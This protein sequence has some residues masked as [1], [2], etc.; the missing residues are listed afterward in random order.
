MKLPSPVRNCLAGFC[1]KKAPKAQP[2]GQRSG[3]SGLSNLPQW[4]SR[5]ISSSTLLS[6]RGKATHSSVS[7][8]EENI[9][10]FFLQWHL[11]SCYGS[12]PAFIQ[13][14]AFY[15]ALEYFRLLLFQAFEVQLSPPSITVFARVTGVGPTHPVTLQQDSI[16]DF[17]CQGAGEEGELNLNWLHIKG[18]GVGT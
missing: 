4:T 11:I 6:H 15:S 16:S 7:I 2:P 12:I 8:W 14:S 1:M 9:S 5:H 13:L 17:L 3:P 10:C 18:D